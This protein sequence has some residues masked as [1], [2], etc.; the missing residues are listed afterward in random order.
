MV[1]QSITC[2]TSIVASAA[3]DQGISEGRAQERVLQHELKNEAPSLTLSTSLSDV[4][5]KSDGSVFVGSESITD[6]VEETLR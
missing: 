5:L 3:R 2:S 6:G 1:V 4:S